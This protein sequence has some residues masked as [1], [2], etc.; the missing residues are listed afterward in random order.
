MQDAVS[1]SLQILWFLTFLP[2]WKEG[3]NDFISRNHLEY[4]PLPK[5][6]STNLM[7]QDLARTIKNLWVSKKPLNQNGGGKKSYFIMVKKNLYNGGG[8]NQTL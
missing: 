1:K 6:K 3:M 4:S 7:S 8:K 5:I 2:K